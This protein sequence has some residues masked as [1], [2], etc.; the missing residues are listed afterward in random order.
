[1]KKYKKKKIKKIL[2]TMFLRL[3]NIVV[4]KRDYLIRYNTYVRDSLSYLDLFLVQ[5]ESQDTTMG[6]C[7]DLVGSRQHGEAARNR[8]SSTKANCLLNAHDNEF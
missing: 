2:F 1:M 8:A 3:L 6:S 4:Y 5:T 7:F